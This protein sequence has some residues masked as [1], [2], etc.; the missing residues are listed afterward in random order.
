MLFETQRQ[1]PKVLHRFDEIYLGTVHNSKFRG[2]SQS[3]FSVIS[4]RRLHFPLP[5]HFKLR[6]EQSDPLRD[7]VRVFS[8]FEEVGRC[9]EVR[10]LLLLRLDR[11]SQ[12]CLVEIKKRVLEERD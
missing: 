5:S 3:P 1:I 6:Y 12:Y 4:A 11:H 7:F 9:K 8:F 2:R 10:S